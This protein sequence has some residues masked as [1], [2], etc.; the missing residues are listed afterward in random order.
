MLFIIQS[1]DKVSG[2]LTLECREGENEL[3][4]EGKKF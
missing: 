4:L 2:H 3:T 1:T